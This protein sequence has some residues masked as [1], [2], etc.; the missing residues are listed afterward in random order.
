M[1]SDRIIIFLLIVNF[2]ILVASIIEKNLSKTL[3]WAGAL[4]LQYGVL[5]G[6]K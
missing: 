1:I 6:M 2:A 3:Y 5:I 4:L